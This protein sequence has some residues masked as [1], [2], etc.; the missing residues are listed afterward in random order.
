MLHPIEHSLGL[1]E[2]A[3]PAQDKDV[4]EMGF[5]V[6]CPHC[7]MTL[8]CLRAKELAHVDTQALTFHSLTESGNAIGVT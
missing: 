7:E 2:V 1:C 4:L 6:T 3:S 5:N 8:R